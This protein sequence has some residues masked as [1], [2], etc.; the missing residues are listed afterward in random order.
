MKTAAI[1]AHNTRKNRCESHSKLLIQIDFF[2]YLQLT[3]RNQ[4]NHTVYSNSGD[5]YKSMANL[6]YLHVFGRNRELDATK[7]K[8]WAANQWWNWEYSLWS[9]TNMTVLQNSLAPPVGRNN[10]SKECRSKWTKYVFKLS[11]CT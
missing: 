10:F 7:K 3:L 6:F 2:K 1:L 11:Y 4:W 5:Y 9:I 8:N